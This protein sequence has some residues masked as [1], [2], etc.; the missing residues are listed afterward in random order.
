MNTLFLKSFTGGHKNPN[1]PHAGTGNQFAVH[2]PSVWYGGTGIKS[3]TR[4]WS[5]A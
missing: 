2:G 4:G 5:D 3:W 1:G